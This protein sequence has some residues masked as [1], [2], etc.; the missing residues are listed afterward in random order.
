MVDQHPTVAAS[1]LD[2]LLRSFQGP[3]RDFVARRVASPAEADDLLQEILLRIAENPDGL[4]QVGHVR[5]WVHRIARNVVV[6]HYRARGRSPVPVAE[7][8]D[9]EDAASDEPGTTSDNRR[10]LAGCLSPLVERLG[11]S[12]REAIRLTEIEGLTQAQ[13]AK[14]AGL[15]LSGMKSRVQRGREQLRDLV[16]ACCEVDLDRRRG[17]ARFE[18]RAAGC[19]CR[20]S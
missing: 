11:E 5:A 19:G 10:A 8:P 4:R 9:A 2:A 15:S 13:A 18:S 16:L 7:V 1:D 20:S 3:L 6:D 14:R 12:Y 17:I